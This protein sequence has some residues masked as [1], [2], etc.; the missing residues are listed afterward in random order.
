[1]VLVGLP[2]TAPP[3]GLNDLD[4]APV[5]KKIT[6]FAVIVYIIKPANDRVRLRV[7]VRSDGTQDIDGGRREGVTSGKSVVEISVVSGSGGRG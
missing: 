7:G 2:Y 6:A 4:W 1:M 5:P 3:I